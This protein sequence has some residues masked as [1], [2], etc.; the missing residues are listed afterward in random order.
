M[1]A[2]WNK[3]PLRRTAL[4]R[5][6]TLAEKTIGRAAGQEV[7]AGDLTVV[8]VGMAMSVDSIA[9]SV[10]KAMR[11][12]FRVPRV[13][14][15]ERVALVDHVAPPATSPL[16]RG[17]RRSAGSSPNRGSPLLRR[18]NR[19]LHQL[20]IEKCLA[21]PGEVVVGSD[22]HSTAYGAIGAFGTGMP[23]TSLCLRHRQDL[24]QGARV[25]AGEPGG[26]PARWGDV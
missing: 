8:N 11:E 17:R 26:Q 23:P 22:S 14:D 13:A 1:A 20:M 6:F 15:P 19:R 9:P 3:T 4:N 18:G 16:P 21:R 7:R 24:A 12:D 10:I 5:G 2:G 25:H